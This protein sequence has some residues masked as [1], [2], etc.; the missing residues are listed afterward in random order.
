MG[1][2][3]L[4]HDFCWG[5]CLAC[6]KEIF[7]SPESQIA[8]INLV[9]T[10][11][12]AVNR[13]FVCLPGAQSGVPGVAPQICRSDLFLDPTF[14]LEGGSCTFLPLACDF[15]LITMQWSPKPQ[16]GQLDLLSR[17]IFKMHPANLGWGCTATMP[18][19]SSTCPTPKSTTRHNFSSQHSCLW[20]LSA[21]HLKN[22]NFIS[23]LFPGC[24][25]RHCSTISQNTSKSAIL[26]DW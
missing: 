7:I 2:M 14:S 25:L 10:S 21:P 16:C 26:C 24:L 8:E 18:Q 6:Y 12:H 11:P 1:G 3:H 17:D 15:P 13:G 5:Y 22:A 20:H 9:P 4:L 19:N 23:V